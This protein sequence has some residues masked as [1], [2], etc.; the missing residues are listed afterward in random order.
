[1]HKSI[2]YKLHNDGFTTA[3]VHTGDDR[4]V[5]RLFYATVHCLMMDH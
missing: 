3:L 1:M 2:Y 5:K 4:K